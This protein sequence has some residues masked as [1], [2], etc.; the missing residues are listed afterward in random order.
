[1]LER[2]IDRFC[3]AGDPRDKWGRGKKRR[4]FSGV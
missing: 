4:K 1:L 3:H 2:V